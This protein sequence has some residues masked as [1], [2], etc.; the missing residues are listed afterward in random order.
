MIDPPGKRY[1]QT[2]ERLKNAI[3]TVGRLGAENGMATDRVAETM[4][5]PASLDDPFLLLVVGETGAGK[6][7]LL[8]ALFGGESDEVGF[9][10][11][12]E[13]IELFQ[14]GSEARE[15]DLSEDIVNVFRPISALKD[16]H[17]LN[18]PGTKAIGSAYHDVAERFLPRAD[19]IFFVFSVKKPW[20]DPTW[21][22]L[23][24]IHRQWNRKIVLVL[25]QCDLRTEEELAAILEHVQKTARH[26]FGQHFPTFAVSAKAAI[27]AKTADHD[28]AEAHRQSGIEPL[29]LYLSGIVE[30]STSRLVKL[31]HACGKARDA[32]EEIKV[33]HDVVS[34]IIRAD[35]EILG[36]LES[37]ARIQ[38]KRT[39]KKHEALF[40]DFDRSFVSVRR[41]AEK[42]LEAE[43]QF[44]SILLPR[45]HGITR[46]EDW[47][48]G[49]TMKAVRRGIESGARIVTEDVDN[50][51][52]RVSDELQ[53]RFH[54]KLSSSGSGRAN[55]DA[56]RRRLSES[57]E[58]ATAALRGISLLEELE[59]LF[60]RRIPRFWG[61]IIT[62]I[63]SGL[64]GVTLTILHRGLPDDAMDLL[65]E[66]VVGVIFT[67]LEWSPW[68]V[69]PLVLAVVCLI[70]AKRVAS[71]SVKQARA[72][73]NSILDL[74][75]ERIA[76]AQRDAFHE[77]TAAFYRDFVALF[78]PLRKV[79][80]KHR[81]SYEPTL[82]KIEKVESSLTEVE[83]VLHPLL[84]PP[85]LQN[86]LK[87]TLVELP[88]TN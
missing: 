63:V 4:N 56:A 12:S 35:D 22:F 79:C 14:H 82:R 24:R 51:W 5:L 57:V 33:R 13:R 72:A 40:A 9:E 29:R 58:D 46:I 18:L 60:R 53:D 15:T 64:A 61:C 21:E 43:F 55:W 7:T 25:Q 83:R 71:R 8:N 86:E 3:E 69:L 20:G 36:K 6:S 38:A 74:Y 54:L 78:E 39:L 31:T 1:F 41:R 27:L 42:I 76:K 80:Q 47:I 62:A 85:N 68:I 19:L 59:G 77:Q 2:R 84:V 52:E 66:L 30:S 17:L 34:E 88:R 11:V 65:V 50:L 87:S 26:R 23:D 67:M 49:I 45:R 73:C 37:I 28:Q 70:V 32:L 16:F 48:S 75:R 10:P 81:M 44:A